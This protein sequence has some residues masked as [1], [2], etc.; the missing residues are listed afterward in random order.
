MAA[1]ERGVVGL[2]DDAARG[3]ERRERLGQLGEPLEV[4]ERRV[5]AYLPLARTVCRRAERLVVG[6]MATED[7]GELPV[8][9][10]NRL[11]D[12]LFVFGRWAARQD[13]RPE[14]LWEPEKT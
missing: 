6:V 1:V 13:G 2:A 7:V 11:S 10:L 9:Y 8:R 12:A 5:S 4:V 14:P 3:V